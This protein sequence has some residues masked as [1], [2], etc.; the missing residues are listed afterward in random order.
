[1]DDSL[2]A[3][4]D[5]LSLEQLLSL[6]QAGVKCGHYCPFDC[7]CFDKFEMKVDPYVVKSYIM[8]RFG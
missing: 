3:Y 7:Q 5:S 4:L 2:R 8:K 6:F 1:M